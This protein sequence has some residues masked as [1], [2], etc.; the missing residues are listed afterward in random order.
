[1]S[2]AANPSLSMEAVSVGLPSDSSFVTPIALP[3]F[4]YRSVGI[5]DAII[6]RSKASR[7]Y[8][9]YPRELDCLVVFRSPV[10]GWLCMSYWVFGDPVFCALLG[11]MM[12][13]R[14]V[15]MKA[16]KDRITAAGMMSAGVWREAL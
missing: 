6:R 14:Y 12:L 4:S 8:P 1:M 10:L 7:T 16:L 13:V 3:C 5:I 11:T 9:D 2:I 15:K